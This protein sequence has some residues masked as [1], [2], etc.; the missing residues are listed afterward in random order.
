MERA[1][2]LLYN[3]LLLRK[4][5]ECGRVPLPAVQELYSDVYA[6]VWES[7]GDPQ[8]GM[9]MVE[10]HSVYF[11]HV[12]A[13]RRRVKN[14]V[15]NGILRCP[16]AYERSL[17]LEELLEN[18]ELRAGLLPFAETL[19][20]LR[21][22]LIGGGPLPDGLA[23]EIERRVGRVEVSVTQSDVKLPASLELECADL[24]ATL[25][26]VLDEGSSSEVWDELWN[27]WL[28]DTSSMARFCFPH[29]EALLEEYRYKRYGLNADER[30][31]FI[32]LCAAGLKLDHSRLSFSAK[33]RI[34]EPASA[35]VT[36]KGGQQRPR[37]LSFW[38]T[39]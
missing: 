6:L 38:N 22:K 5:G 19:L 32:A 36:P 39:R 14:E 27:I 33:S 16:D 35:P 1:E 15:L 25:Q 37:R 7:G 10:H 18:I 17:R 28:F 26:V 13:C 8:I 30:R 23:K 21:D 4:K 12:S 20:Y 24:W 29:M 31:E 3:E 2:L 9:Y 11:A 34:V